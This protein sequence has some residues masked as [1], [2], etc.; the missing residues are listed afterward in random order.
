MAP[1]LFIGRLDL[2]TRK[3]ELEDVFTKYGQWW[4]NF[5]TQ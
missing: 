1:Q 3:E 5:S 2:S 4:S